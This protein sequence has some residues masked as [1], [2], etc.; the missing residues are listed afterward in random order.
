[1]KGRV[2]QDDCFKLDHVVLPTEIFLSRHQDL[3]H[4]KSLGIQM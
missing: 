3:A 1:M 4:R 2:F